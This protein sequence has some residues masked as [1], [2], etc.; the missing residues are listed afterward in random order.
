MAVWSRH[1][2]SAGA[3]RRA[4]PERKRPDGLGSLQDVRHVAVE[5]VVKLSPSGYGEV[6]VVVVAKVADQSRARLEVHDDT[7]LY[8]QLRALVQPVPELFFRIGRV[9]VDEGRWS[10]RLIH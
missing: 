10:Q 6:E 8:G 1:W 9:I 7:Q 5:D 3:S 4:L 2:G